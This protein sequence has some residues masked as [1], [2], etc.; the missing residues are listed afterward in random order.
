LLRQSDYDKNSQYVLVNTN[1]IIPLFFAT[2]VFGLARTLFLFRPSLWSSILFLLFYLCPE[3]AYSAEPSAISPLR[4]TQSASDAQRAPFE[5]SW[6][7]LET[8]LELGLAL[9][10]ESRARQNTNAFVVLR[11]TPTK[12]TFALCMASQTGMALAPAKWSELKHLRAGINGGMYLPDQLTNTGYMRNGEFVNNSKLGAKLNAF[13]VAGPRKKN[14][15]PADIID[16]DL[17]NWQ[18][19]LDQYDIVAQNYR[20]INS[21]G[22]LLWPEGEEEHSIAVI[23][24][25]SAGRILFILCQQPLTIQG[26]TRYLQGLSLDIETVMYVEGGRHAAL[27][28]RLDTPENAVKALPGATV[29]PISDGAAVMVWRGKQSLFK[30]PGNPDALLPNIIGVKIRPY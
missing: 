15:A 4:H 2:G 13:F 17:P 24:K 18:T 10:P 22:E 8:G 25:D 1:R 6:H 28:V 20:L 11:I 19:R 27:F 30:L 9:L 21:R 29:H 23:A 14:L 16:K 5:L 7:S 26:F 12:Q 3:P